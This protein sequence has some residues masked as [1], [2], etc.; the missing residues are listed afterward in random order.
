MKTN[1]GV[2]WASCVV[3]VIV[4]VIYEGFNKRLFGFNQIGIMI[5]SHGIAKV[6]SVV[7]TFRP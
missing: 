7:L 6:K 5:N 4:Y 2:A 1:T 3:M